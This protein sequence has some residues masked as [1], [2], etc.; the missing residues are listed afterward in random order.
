MSGC[1]RGRIVAVS[2]KDSFEL[3]QELDQLRIGTDRCGGRP[4]T[5][6]RAVVTCTTEPSPTTTFTAW[7]AVSAEGSSSP[8]GS[9]RRARYI[10]DKCLLSR[11]QPIPSPRLPRIS[12][13]YPRS[14]A[15]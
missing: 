11:L 14:L 8:P 9:D 6:R 2:A 1:L 4:V 7:L 5:S 15:R 12:P 3:A 10:S 13:R